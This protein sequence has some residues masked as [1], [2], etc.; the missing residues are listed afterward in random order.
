LLR[1]L[2]Y[3]IVLES[4][5]P[6]IARL[7]LPPADVLLR[8]GGEQVDLRF[9]TGAAV[10]PA[11]T[12]SF[13]E[14]GGDIG[15]WGLK[16]TGLLSRQLSG[17]GATVLAIPRPPM[18]V[19]RAAQA[20]R[21]ACAEL[22]FQLFVGSALRRARMRFGDPD[23]SVAAHPDATIRVRLTS[24]LDDDFVEEYRWPL[25]PADDLAEVAR[26]IFGLLAEVRL[27]RVTVL[28]TVIGTDQEE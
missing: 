12:A 20:G 14:S 1:S 16:F 17:N 24:S 13:L 9:I 5:G 18:S 10:A 11:D 27:D 28:D 21:F 8:S 3:R 4:A 6:E 19:I 26:S 25:A 2:L 7:D 22:G 15:R 23:V